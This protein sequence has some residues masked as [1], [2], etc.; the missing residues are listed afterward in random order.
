MTVVLAASTGIS[1]ATRCVKQKEKA[2]LTYTLFADSIDDF[3][4]R[5]EGL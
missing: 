1:S 5:C 4:G 3:A 2:H